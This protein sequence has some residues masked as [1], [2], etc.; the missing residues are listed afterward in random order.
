MIHSYNNRLVGKKGNRHIRNAILIDFIKNDLKGIEGYMKALQIVYDQ[1][2][3][4]EYLFNHVIPIV[5][6]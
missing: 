6:D 3:M 2:L 5:A 1:E 4:Q